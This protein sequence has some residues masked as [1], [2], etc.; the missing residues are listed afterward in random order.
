MCGIAG[1]A[2]EVGAGED[3]LRRMCAAIAHRGPDAAGGHVVPGKVGL[4]FRRLAII[5]LQTGDQPIAAEAGDVHVTC[6]GEIYN[7][8]PLR[9]ELRSRGHAFATRSDSEVVAHLYEERGPGCLEALQGMFAIALWDAGAERLLLAR[10]RLGVKPLYW[11]RVGDGI[12]YASEPAA[13]L[14][15]GLVEPRPDPAALREYLTLQYVPPPRSGF[16]GIHKLAPGERLVFAA[17]EATVERWWQLDFERRR[18]G[19]DR[20]ALEELDELLARATRERLVADVPL[21]AFLSGGI[22]SSLVVSYMAEAGGRVRTF[23]IDFP[24]ARFSEGEHA[25]RVAAIYGTEHEERVLEPQMVPLVADAVRFAGEPFADSSAIP[26]LL[27]SR[28]TRERVTVALS[29]DGGDEAFAG[30]RRY[31]VARTAERLGPAAAAA[32]LLQ[33]SGLPG[34]LPPAARQLRRAIDAFALPPPQRYASMMS[35]FAPTELESLCTPDFLAAAGDP[36]SAWRQTLAP[37]PLDGVDRYLALDT[38]TYLPGDLLLKVD[39]M[40]MADALEVRSPFLDYRVHEFAAA[41]PERLKLR[42]RTTKWALKKLAAQRGLP[43]D[44]VNRRKQGFGVPVGTW[45]RGPLRPWLEDLL[46]EPAS[47]GR[48]YFDPVRV[49]RLVGEHLDGSADHTYRLW[50]LAVLELWHRTWVDG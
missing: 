5:D 6:N 12:L 1:W 42:G 49:R 36:W 32:R 46:L 50:N 11:A 3:T 19:S 22:D 28:M 7:F 27:L 45:L 38:A 15:S 2:G 29:G 30:Y 37:P 13:I 17:G 4:G 21:G 25:R 39:R 41:L 16:A 44:L 31:L 48:G 8:A 34:Q 47:L 14:A 43:P 9:E 40:S 24:E 33:R 23:S 26:T 18:E 35:H 10:D 20:E